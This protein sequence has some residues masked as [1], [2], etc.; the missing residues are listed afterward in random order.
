MRPWRQPRKKRDIVRLRYAPHLVGSTVESPETA[1]DAINII[2]NERTRSGSAN[3]HRRGRSSHSR[4]RDSAKAGSRQNSRG[5]GLRVHRMLSH[6]V[7]R[8]YGST[9][10]A[11]GHKPKQRS[12]QRKQYDATLDDFSRGEQ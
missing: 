11:S 12:F 1:K 10:A 6:D 8:A 5:K 7:D 3:K 9:R 4:S 2:V